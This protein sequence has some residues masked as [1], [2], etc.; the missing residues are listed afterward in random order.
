MFATTRFCTYTEVL[1]HITLLLLGLRI[2]FGIPKPSLHRGSLLV[3]EVSL[4][5]NKKNYP[6]KSVYS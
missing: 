2:S 4:Y 1:F 5:F 3:S 6:D